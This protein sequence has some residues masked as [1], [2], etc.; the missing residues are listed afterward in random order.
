M[1][2]TIGSE[3]T[4]SIEAG[5]DDTFK[6]Y[7]QQIL[8][9][10]HAEVHPT[11]TTPQSKRFTIRVTDQE[12]QGMG[13]AIVWTYW[14]W[15]EISVLA[16]EKQARGQG[17]GRQLM[18]RIEE[19]AQKE[20]CTRARVEAFEHETGFYQ[21]LGYQVLGCLEDYPEGHNYYWLRKD[22]LTQDEQ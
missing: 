20:G 9:E 6:R 19:L 17:L 3:Y 4:F 16:L 2:T 14:G 22:L 11:M 10:Y 5:G 15:L 18:A 7:L 21:R 1:T 12:G 8:N 13:G